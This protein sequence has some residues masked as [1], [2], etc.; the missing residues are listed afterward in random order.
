MVTVGNKWWI[1]LYGI[2][3]VAKFYASHEEYVEAMLA[4]RQRKKHQ[5]SCTMGETN[6]QCARLGLGG[7]EQLHARQEENFFSNGCLK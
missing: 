1:M 7:C 4:A 3:I 2:T 5:T 6:K